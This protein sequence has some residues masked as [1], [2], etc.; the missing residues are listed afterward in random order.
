M[1]DA[2]DLYVERTG[3]VFDNA[4][5]LLSITS[6]QYDDLQSLFFDIGGKTYELNKNAQIWPRALNTFIGGEKDGIYLVVSDLG[7]LLGQAETPGFDFIVGMVFLERYYSVYD[8][9]NN[10]VGF[11]TT[12]FTNMTDFN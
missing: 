7:Q 1:L 3:G 12:R 4:T 6:A 10:R 5:G 11:A 2:Y 8:T 9:T